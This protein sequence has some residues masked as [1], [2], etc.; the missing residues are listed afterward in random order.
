MPRKE[1]TRSKRGRGRDTLL[2]DTHVTGLV[3]PFE[4]YWNGG[5]Q[6]QTD[7]LTTRYMTSFYTSGQGDTGP[8]MPDWQR[9]QKYLE[10]LFAQYTHNY[11]LEIWKAEKDRA[12]VFEI[13]FLKY[14]GVQ[15]KEELRAKIIDI[16]SSA[17][18][19]ETLLRNYDTYQQDFKDMYGLLQRGENSTASRI[20]Q[21]EVEMADDLS[22]DLTET[23]SNNL[24]KYWNDAIVELFDNKKGLRR[25]LEDLGIQVIPITIG[26]DV[27]YK[28]IHVPKI[29]HLGNYGINIDKRLYKGAITVIKSLADVQKTQKEKEFAKKLFTILSQAGKTIP[30][31]FSQE[32]IL[33]MAKRTLYDESGN[34][35]LMDPSDPKTIVMCH[36]YLAVLGKPI[37]ELTKK[38]PNNYRALLIN[39]MIG[40]LT[41]YLDNVNDKLYLTQVILDM[42]NSPGGTQAFFIGNNKLN[43]AG[44]LG[45]IVGGFILH[46]LK[47]GIKS[48][49]LD[50]H[51]TYN[52]VAKQ[53]GEDPPTDFLLNVAMK[54]YGIQVK[55]VANP[56]VSY[57]SNLFELLNKIKATQPQTK[58][59]MDPRKFAYFYASQS[60][61]AAYLQSNLQYIK[62]LN[63]FLMSAS[64]YIYN[65]QTTVNDLGRENVIYLLGDNVVFATEILEGLSKAFQ[66]SPEVSKV[67]AT[68][69]TLDTHIDV[70]GS[71][72]EKDPKS[73]INTKGVD[74]R[75]PED[76]LKQIHYSS[77]L[78]MSKLISANVNSWTHKKG[79]SI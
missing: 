36:K 59:D 69:S 71:I 45:E 22:M 78:D 25:A 49:T 75:D 5:E 14:F 51:L 60:F 30:F 18:K 64:S 2:N 6:Y 41:Q 29:G 43:I 32:D 53:K 13:R 70:S 61:Y 76:F 11:S 44:R 23:W 17:K 62:N 65:L 31:G 66:D 58:V 47:K 40:D 63:N 3:S 15:T 38:D 48:T 19:I 34:V 4:K 67:G 77:S 46:K 1:D 55:N 73:N 39:L 10:G 7:V 35:V 26:N 21:F 54:N 9:Y 16:I 33:Q 68:F 24:L 56:N 74:M 72:V 79:G 37:N 28:A 8:A 27:T 50:S 42:A 12:H 52:A 20:R 57:D